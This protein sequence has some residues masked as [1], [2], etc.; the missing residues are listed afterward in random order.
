[1]EYDNVNHPAHYAGATS[2]ECIDAMELAF[3]KEGVFL[4]CLGNAFKY[5]WRYRNKNGRE[6]LDKAEW[7]LNRAHRNGLNG[8][9]SAYVEKYYK[10][11]GMLDEI[12]T[13]Q[14]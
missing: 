6:D 8:I 7:Y 12:D 3:G 2:M 1:M 4:I 5:L 9:P 11:R 14:C 13:G 10:L